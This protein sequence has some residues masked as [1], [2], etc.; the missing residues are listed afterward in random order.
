MAFPVP[1]ENLRQ[2][3]KERQEQMSRM[4]HFK[5]ESDWF[6]TQTMIKAAEW[7]EHNARRDKWFLWVDTFEVHEVWHSPPYYVDLFD[8]GYEGLDYDAPNYGYTDIYTKNELRHLWAHYAAEVTMT[9]RWLGYLLDQM[10]AMD[11]WNNTLVIFISDHGMYIG[12]HNR[13][14]K[15]TVRGEADPWPLYEE[16]THIPLLVWAPKKGMKKRI[17]SLA[18]P[19]DAAATILDA[20]GVAGPKMH[21]RSWLPLMTGRRTRN[22]DVV[23]SSKH[24]Q[25]PEERSYS[26]GRLTATTNRWTLIARE[27]GRP[28]ELYDIKSDPRQTRNLARKRP[29]IVEALQAG[30]LVFLREQNA[31]ERYIERYR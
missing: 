25:P 13:A 27:R 6:V 21:G 14:G 5:Q 18:Q 24:S 22:W 28:A 7:L 9:D 29:D 12:E 15:H 23:Y 10:D 31:T 26:I 11:L 8:P 17:Q 1:P 3:G 19:A 30:A 16:I 4:A 20:T 2:G